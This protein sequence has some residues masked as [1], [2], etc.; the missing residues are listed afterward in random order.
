MGFREDLKLR[1][2]KKRTEIATLEEKLNE[3]GVYLRALEDTFKLLPHEEGEPDDVGSV[4]ASVMRVGT[5]IAHAR[6]IL[7]K[8]GHPM[9]VSE[10]LAA[11]KLPFD[12]NTRAALSGS[13]GAYVRK[14][15]VFTRPAPNTFGL[16]GMEG[17]RDQRNGPPP[18]FGLEEPP[19]SDDAQLG[20]D[21]DIPF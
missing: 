4:S 8:S 6:E 18:D 2:E 15:E 3:A 14:G 1:I 13:L 7:Q 9:H 21:L 17:G 19:G 20:A 16:I 12:N 10:L 5:R 11:M